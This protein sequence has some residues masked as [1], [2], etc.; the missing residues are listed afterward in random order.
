MTSLATTATRT[1]KRHVRRILVLLGLTILV[2]LGLNNLVFHL[3]RDPRHVGDAQ[4]IYG[5][6]RLYK[7]MIFDSVKPKSVAF[8][9]SWVRDIFD[10]VT[11]EELTGAPFFNFGISGATSFE[12]FRLIQNMLA[13]HRPE[14]VYLDVESFYDAPLASRVEHQFDERILYVN[15][16]GSPNPSA[17]LQRL[18]KINTSGAALGF[19]FAFLDLLRKEQAGTA[20]RDLLPSYERRDWREYDDLIKDMNE[21]MTVPST[22]LP[23]DRGKGSNKAPAFN[24][25]EN[26]MRL[27]C[28]AGID[29]HLYEAPYI[30][31]GDGTVTR[32]ALTM[33][34]RVAKACKS[35]ITYHSFRYPNAVTIEG[36]VRDPGPSLFYRPDGHP[37]PPL[38]QL[39]LTRIKG[40]QNQPEAPALPKDFGRDLMAMNEPE[41]ETWIATKAARCYGQ[42]L[43]GEYDAT[44]AEARQLL[45]D[46]QGRY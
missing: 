11:A 18:I 33:A 28:D 12:S 15:R 4:M 1:A 39:M 36:I 27:L 13:V 8:G 22:P 42:W 35:R 43:P 9:F 24:D 40:L 16:D 30:C 7:P 46:W 3:I 14:E 44:R 17:D 31:G 45:A 20:R 21:W 29:I 32:T 37:R 2:I 23:T 26:G 25:L 6:G 10:P 34:R 5:W 38:G 41:A 19:N